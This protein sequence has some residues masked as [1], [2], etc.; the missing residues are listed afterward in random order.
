MASQGSQPVHY[1]ETARRPAG[2]PSDQPVWSITVFALAALIV[3]ARIALEYGEHWSDLG[4]HYIP[5]YVMTAVGPSGT[6]W[7]LNTV[8]RHGA[9]HLTTSSEVQA[10]PVTGSRYNVRV[11]P[12]RLT[13]AAVEDGAKAL[14]WSRID[15]NNIKLHAFLRRGVYRAR[16]LPELAKQGAICAGVFLI[17]GLVVA[18]P[19]D[20]KAQRMYQEGRVVRGPLMVTRDLFNRKRQRRGRTSGIGFVTKESQSLWERLI[21]KYFY[22]PTARIP[23]EDE[24]RHM[25]LVGNTGGGR[26]R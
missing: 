3:P 13:T 18:V 22:G 16:P 7:I 17:F 11:M 19:Q 8:T 10:V 21:M 1:Q 9:M 20:R 12:F 5:Q 14:Q 25:L 15:A 6:Y 2:W 23:V 26:A 4:A 24:P